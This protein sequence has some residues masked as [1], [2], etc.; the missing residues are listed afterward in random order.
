MLLTYAMVYCI[1]A[2][3]MNK[4]SVPHL[5][6]HNAKALRKDILFYYYQLAKGIVL[7]LAHAK[8]D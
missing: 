8:E 4:S 1:L 2:E 3:K 5:L 6:I 7:T